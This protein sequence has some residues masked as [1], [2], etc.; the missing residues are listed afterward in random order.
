MEP[1][2]GARG[3][4]SWRGPYLRKHLPADPWDRPYIY[5]RPAWRARV[6]HDRRHWS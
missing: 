1:P 5:G 4:K 6:P 3:S 2:S